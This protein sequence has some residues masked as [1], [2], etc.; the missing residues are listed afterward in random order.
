M[1]LEV[2]RAR[3]SSG[4]VDFSEDGK[5]VTVEECSILFLQEAKWFVT[6]EERKVLP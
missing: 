6:L 3:G 1:I 2:P 5:K 4:G